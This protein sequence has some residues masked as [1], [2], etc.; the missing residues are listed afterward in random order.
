MRPVAFAVSIPSRSD[1]STIP[2]PKVA[3]GRHH[4]SSVAAQAVDANNHDGVALARVVQQ[5]G[6]S[7]ALRPR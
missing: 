2:A 5:R 1:R 7:G 4:L 3:D 6:E